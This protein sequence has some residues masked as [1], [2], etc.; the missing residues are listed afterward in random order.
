MERKKSHVNLNAC[1]YCL[2]SFSKFSSTGAIL[3]PNVQPSVSS[4][5]S[6]LP[7]Q[8]EQAVQ[9]KGFHHLG[10]LEAHWVQDQYL[11]STEA[12]TFRSWKHQGGRVWR[13]GSTRWALKSGK[14]L[15]SMRSNTPMTAKGVGKMCHFWNGFRIVWKILFG[16]GFGCFFAFF[17]GTICLVFATVLN[18]LHGICYIL[19][20]LLCILHGICYCTFG[21]VRLPFCMVFATFWHFNLSFAWYLLHFGTSNVHVGFLRVSLGFH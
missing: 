15:D 5:S 3:Q 6:L 9:L 7:R 13:A 8:H 18:I 20:W 1:Q 21:H 4:Y 17:P 16:S 10:E 11:S 2:V 19:A 12:M 14:F